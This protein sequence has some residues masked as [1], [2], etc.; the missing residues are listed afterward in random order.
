METGMMSDFLQNK[1]MKEDMENIFLTQES[2]DS[3]KNKSVYVTGASGMIASYLV[4][5]LI[6]LNETKDWNIQIYAGIRN[7][8]KA[9]KRFGNYVDKSYFHL[10]QKDVILPVDEDLRLDYI[11]HAASLAS[12]QYYGKMPV[13]T[14]LPNMIGTYHL[15]EY[16]RK[17]PVKNFLFFSSGSVYGSISDVES[18]EEHTKGAMDFLSVGNFYGESKRCGEAL[19]KA[20]FLEYGIPVK[21]IRIQHTYGPT[22]DIDQDKRVFSEFVHNIVHD[23]NIVLKSDG[24]GKRAFC[25]ITDMI[26]AVFAVI[27]HGE[28]GESYNAGN[29]QEYISILELAQTLVSLFPEKNLQVIRE[30]RSDRGYSASTE[31]RTIPINLEKMKGLGWKPTCSLTDGFYRTISYHNMIKRQENK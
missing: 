20:Y 17:Y 29:D 2:W 9:R 24:S 23:Q 18:I 5:F 16:A 28:N 14:M 22:L 26:A 7:N 30:Q 21:S 31:V 12:P 3:L 6:Y 11:I 13:E 8:Q 25:Y 27:L 4:M 1:I 15:L 19:G 10:M